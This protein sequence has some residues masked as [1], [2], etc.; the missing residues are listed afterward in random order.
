MHAVKKYMKIKYNLDDDLPL[1]EMIELRKMIIVVRSD[2]HEG[3]K[4]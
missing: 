1:N 3:N 2:F 4:Y